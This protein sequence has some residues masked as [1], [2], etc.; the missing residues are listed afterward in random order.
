MATKNVMRNPTE[1]RS[2]KTFGSKK[3]RMAPPAIGVIIWP[4]LFRALLI[5]NI[6]ADSVWSTLLESLLVK[7]GLTM[8]DP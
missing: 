3:R 2:G 1:L 4:K 6:V 8:P 5:P 7:I